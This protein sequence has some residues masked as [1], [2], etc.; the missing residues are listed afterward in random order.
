KVSDFIGKKQIMFFHAG[1]SK[2]QV[3]GSLIAALD[4]SDPNG[5]LKAIFSR[6][7]AGSTIISP[8]LAVP[9]AR[10]SGIRRL[11][12]AVGLCPQGI[13]DSKSKAEPVRIFVLFLGPADNMK[14]HLGF[15]AAVSALFQRPGF[16]TELLKQTTP[17]SVLSLITQEEKKLS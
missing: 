4:L 10:I 12:A 6:E 16:M 15:L 1:P 9:H 3:F 5:A 2:A 17:D 14:E 7:E 8:G 13:I 11:K